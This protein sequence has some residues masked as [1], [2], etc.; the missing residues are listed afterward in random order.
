MKTAIVIPAR[1]QSSRLPEKVLADLGGKPLIQRVYDACLRA[2]EVDEVWIA[3]DHERVEAVCRTFTSH[4]IRTSEQHESG[5]DR[6]A[7]AARGL[8]ADYI[9]NVQGDEPFIDA[10]TIDAVAVALREGQENMV[11]VYALGEDPTGLEDP[12]TVKV[13]TDNAGYALYFSRAPIPF[14]RDGKAAEGPLFQKHIGLYG[15]ASAFLQTFAGL[16][17][18]HLEQ[19]EKLEQLRALAH[20]YKIKMLEVS[21]P[22]KGIDTLEDLEQARKKFNL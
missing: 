3:C 9:I 1:L 5:T 22:E 2:T 13:V 4:V 8:Q 15:Y 17:A 18:A 10:A 11:S 20:G 16:P 14:P 12:N 19:T 21:H 6:I 7:E